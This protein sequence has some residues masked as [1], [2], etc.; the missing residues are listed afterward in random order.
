MII[1]KKLPQETIGSASVRA[2]EFVYSSE[3]PIYVILKQLV[4][5]KLG[6]KITAFELEKE[7]SLNIEYRKAFPV[8]KPPKP[9][10][11][12]KPK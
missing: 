4:G 3:G 5:T 6:H 2:A 1:Y 11:K 8:G 10:A 9:K 12:P 7:I